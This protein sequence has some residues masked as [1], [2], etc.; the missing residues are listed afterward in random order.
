MFVSKLAWKAAHPIVVSLGE[1]P[2]VTD[3]SRFPKNARSTMLVTEFGM[4]T[5]VRVQPWKAELAIA[6]I[7]PSISISPEQ[8]APLWLFL[9]TQPVVRAA[10][11]VGAQSES[12]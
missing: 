11:V 10:A 5:L 9:F 2:K 1:L 8:Q 12:D 7:D 3:A 4:N 6:V